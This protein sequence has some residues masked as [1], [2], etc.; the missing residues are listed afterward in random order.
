MAFALSAASHSTESRSTFGGSKAAAS[1][2]SG[3]DG[4]SATPTRRRD[5][6]SGSRRGRA[7]SRRSRTCGRRAGDD[8]DDIVLPG[9]RRLELA[10]EPR[11]ECRSAD[12]IYSFARAQS[13]LAATG[14][15]RRIQC[16]SPQLR[17]PAKG[18]E[19]IS[20]SRRN[21]GLWIDSGPSRGDALEARF[22]PLGDDRY[23]LSDGP[24]S[25]P[26][27]P[28]AV[29]P[30][31]GPKAPESGLRLEASVGPSTDLGPALRSMEFGSLYRLRAAGDIRSR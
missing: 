30:A 21:H 26:L 9:S 20:R 22:P 3:S 23:M 1:C 15:R 6:S 2:C 11:R 14:R 5:L 28:F 16:S 25:D 27:L 19:A 12:W 24:P 10:R 13:A 8:G 17:T 29:D 4:R 18:G 7:P 31:N